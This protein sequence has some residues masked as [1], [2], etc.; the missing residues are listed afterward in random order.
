MENSTSTN[1]FLFA[2]SLTDRACQYRS[3]VY[4]YHHTWA[5]NLFPIISIILITIRARASDRTVPHIFPSSL[6]E[7]SRAYTRGP[8]HESWRFRLELLLPLVTVSFIS[9]FL[10]WSSFLDGLAVGLG[11]GKEDRTG[12][13]WSG[14][15]NEW[16]H[17]CFEV[18]VEE[19]NDTRGLGKGCK[20]YLEGYTKQI[21]QEVYILAASLVFQRE[22]FCI[23]LWAR[24][25]INVCHWISLLES[26]L[27]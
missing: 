8:S 19:W 17:I 16:R 13:P 22:A 20:K 2:I 4:L 23:C 26:N 1:R 14:V 18:G 21:V 24:G 7:Q 9:C 5:H 3:F 10:A 25:V 27:T 11:L 12:Q 15:R 6:S